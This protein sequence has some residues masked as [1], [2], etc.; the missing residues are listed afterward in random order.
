[1]LSREEDETGA[2][3]DGQILLSSNRLEISPGSFTH[4]FKKI[5][6]TMR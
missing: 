4:V 3:N 6:P 5:E 2:P 1:M